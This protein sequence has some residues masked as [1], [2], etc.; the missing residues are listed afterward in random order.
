VRIGLTSGAQR[1]SNARPNLILSS[2]DAFCLSSGLGVIHDDDRR[3]ATLERAA[4]ARPSFRCAGYDRGH[5]L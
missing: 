2:A 4:K 3:P 1:D 5:N